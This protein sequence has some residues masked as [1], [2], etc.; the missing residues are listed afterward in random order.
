MDIYQEIARLS[1]EN[2]PFVLAT[3]VKI[4]GSV[5]GKVGFKL[6]VRPDGTATGTVGG[7]E[8]EQRVIAESLNRLKTG[9]SGLKEYLLTEKAEGLAPSEAEIVPMMCS[10]KTWIY[11]EVS[12]TLPTVYL[13]GGGHVGQALA[14]FLAKLDYRIVLVDNRRE[15]A[16]PEMNPH[17]SERV[18]R[19]YRE[20]AREFEPA[21]D[22]FVVVMTQGHG[23]DYD[24][25]KILYQ[26][27][28]P[29][30]YIGVIA[31]RAKSAGL[32]KHLKKDFGADVDLRR[33]YSP[34]GLDIGG[35]TESEIALSIAAEIQA[36]R[37]G[38]KVP[39]LG[40]SG[41]R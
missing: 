31:S 40:R 41:G 6:L 28:L 35:D 23:Y 12:H 33:L 22:S 15:F 29:L 5:P 18:Y 1:Q 20:F 25:V 16:T 7:G 19:D 26:R 9:E 34:I 38:R 14:Y 21:P 32:M 8:L 10:G 30:K 11:Y 3:V 36:I 4:A 27:E 13:F 2:Q 37:F 24:V 39:H 17:A